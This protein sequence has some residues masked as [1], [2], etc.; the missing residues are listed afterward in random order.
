M[1]NIPSKTSL[2]LFTDILDQAEIKDGD[3]VADLGCGRSLI[4]LNNLAKQVGENGEVHGIDI[5]P[6]I[7]ES[8]ERDIK[9]YDLR[10]IKV[11]KSDLEKENTQ[12][13]NNYFQA[14]FFINTLHQISDSLAAL[15]EAYRILDNKGKL[16]I[17]DWLKK[18]SPFG[19]HME[20]RIEK[21]HLAK[22]A[23]L[24]NLNITSQF[25][26]GPYHYGLVLTK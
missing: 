7:V 21:S 25:E 1:K 22:I 10:K 18:E 13:I 12:F 4:F 6:E 14:L 2:L 17:V 23:S 8:L 16:V 26:P 19:P 15:S 5:H 3:K 9:H 11:T 20:Q 24:L